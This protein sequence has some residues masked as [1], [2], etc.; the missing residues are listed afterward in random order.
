MLLVNVAGLAWL[1]RPEAWLAALM[2]VGIAAPVI[3]SRLSFGRPFL[4]TMAVFITLLF[5]WSSQEDSRPGGRSLLASICLMAAAA[6]IH[7]SAWYLL[8]FPAVALALSGLWHRAIWFLVCW[9]TGSFIGASLTGHPWQFLSQSVQ[10]LLGA[11]GTNDLTRQ[12]VSE[13][14]PTTGD[15]GAVILVFAMLLWRSRNP[16]WKPQS[17]LNPIFLM[18][19][20]GWLL[21]LKVIRFSVD[22]ALPALLVWLALQFQGQFERYLAFDSWRRLFITLGLAA[23]CFLSFTSDV[24]SRW[25]W[26]MTLQFLR[27]EDPHLAG[28][29]PEK[30]GIIYSADMQVF[31]F[32]FF[33]NPTAPWRYV[34]GFEP[35]LMRPEDLAVLRQAQ[36]NFGDSRAYEPWVRKMRPQDR[37]ILRASYSHLTGRPNLPQLEWL[38]AANDYW[39]G[40]LPR[41]NNAQSTAQDPQPAVQSAQ[42][43]PRP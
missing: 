2:S 5:L 8:A 41:T 17:L 43:A 6:W 36:W 7:G 19:V 27:A 35:G 22:W 34:L 32:T 14:L 16:D 10:L 38:F 4:F 33:K 31:Y 42:S 3:V 39:I 11:F 18:C 13:F 37:L 1:R 24:N 26:N 20:L 12:L 21:G 30:D 28:W 29:M 9:L 15:Y 25:T 40:R 23:G